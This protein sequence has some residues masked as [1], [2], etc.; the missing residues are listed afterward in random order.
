[1]TTPVSKNLREPD[2]RISFPGVVE[3]VVEIGGLTV[4]RVVQEPGWRWSTHVRPIVGG[5]WCQARHVGVVLAG[6]YGA[7]F[8]DGTTAEFGPDDVYDIRPGHDGWT[9]GDE[10]AVLIEWAGLRAFAGP[11]AGVHGRVLATL[12]FTDLVDSTAT[13]VRLGE[14]VWRE[15]LS[16]HYGAA[17]AELERFRGREITT[18]GD[19]LLAMFDGPALALRCAAAVRAGAAR[20]S[21]SIRAGVH[22]GEVQVAGSGI[23]GV[24]VHEAA[25]IMAAAAPDE[26][27]VSET[28]KALAEPA[29]LTFEDR[30]THQLKGLPDARRL[31]AYVEA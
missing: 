21:L 24:A 15:A 22:V 10:P 7:L 17:R 9:I 16:L 13:A 8:S 28:T 4:G 6:R 25:R 20:A 2:D 29:G 3:D 1:V 30:G 12:L 31:Y 18:T 26:I 27:L 11:R 14:T 19:G 5:D 23:Q